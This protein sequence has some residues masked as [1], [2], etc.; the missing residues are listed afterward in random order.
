MITSNTIPKPRFRSPKMIFYIGL[1]YI[2]T[3]L[4]FLWY[5]VRPF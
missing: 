5:A 1:A 2:G 4:G 3:G